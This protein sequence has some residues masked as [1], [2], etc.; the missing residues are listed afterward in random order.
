MRLQFL[1]L[2]LTL[3]LLGCHS[4]S[5]K[6]FIKNIEIRVLDN[7]TKQW[8]P[9]QKIS[10][11]VEGIVLSDQDQFVIDSKT[12]TT[13]FRLSKKFLEDA[14]AWQY[15]YPGYQRGDRISELKTKIGESDNL[16]IATQS[17]TLSGEV[18][19]FKISYITIDNKS[20]ISEVIETQGDGKVSY[21]LNFDYSNL[22][23]GEILVKQDLYG[24]QVFEAQLQVI[25][26][27]VGQ[28]LPDA[29]LMSL[30]PLRKHRP[31]IYSG[32][33]G[34]YD[35]LITKMVVTGDEEYEQSSTF[36]RNKQ[37]RVLKQTISHKG[38]FSYLDY[39]REYSYRY[40]FGSIGDF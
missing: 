11:D 39:T 6:P 7:S 36:K 29:Q 40:T 25:P 35:Y 20:Y 3:A 21:T 34:V 19:Q 14:A 31:L 13:D 27:G 32:L 18:T 37:G 4:S 33:M 17:S 30:Y 8:L 38:K 10:F 5:E 12:Y 16:A 22:S 24:N 28:L 23:A 2:T 9:S 1:F 15:Y 26:A